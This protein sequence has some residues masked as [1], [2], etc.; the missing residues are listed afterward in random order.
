MID[1]LFCTVVCVLKGKTCGLSTQALFIHSTCVTEKLTHRNL[2]TNTY[3]YTHVHTDTH[4]NIPTYT[5]RKH[6]RT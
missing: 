3:T 5:T 4:T 2:N 6:T 1:V